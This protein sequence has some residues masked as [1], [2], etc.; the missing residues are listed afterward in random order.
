MG[1]SMVHSR[2]H[3]FAGTGRGEIV[4][5]EPSQTGFQPCAPRLPSPLTIVD[6]FGGAGASPASRSICRMPDGGHSRTHMEEGGRVAAHRRDYWSQS[7]MPLASIAAVG[8]S[9]RW[10]PC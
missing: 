2:C 10:R 3:A 8:A 9:C 5:P 1:W 7:F 4:R 6:A